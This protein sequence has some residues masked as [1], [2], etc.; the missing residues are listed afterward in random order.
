MLDI[1]AAAQK[2]AEPASSQILDELAQT[3]Y[4]AM[5]SS[6]QIDSTCWRR[7]YTDACLLRSLIDI[8]NFP[9]SDD[10]DIPKSVIERLDCV[11]I[12][13]GAPGEGRRDLIIDLISKIQS[14]CLP[15]KA[16]DFSAFHD[17]SHSDSSQVPSILTSSGLIPRLSKPPSL[18]QFSRQFSQTPFILPGYAADWPALNEHPWRSKGYLKS[19]AGRGRVVPVEVGS[20]YRTE[21]WSQQMMEWDR[22][23]E[24]LDTSPSEKNP[25]LYLA[26][27]N[28]LSQF[29]A[30]RADIIVPDYVYTC[31]AAPSDYP[32]YRPPGNE[33]QLVIN[34]WLGPKGTV[35]PAHTDPYFNF[36]VQ[37]VGR[38]TVW[39]APPGATPSM[40]PYPPPT[41][42][43]AVDRRYNPV[44]N[45]LEP[46]MSNTSRVDVFASP[47]QVDQ[48]VQQNYPLFW[49]DVVP[50]ATSV[51]LEPG[52]VL[53]F[54]PGWWHAMRSEE[55]S[56]SV[57]MWF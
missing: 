9:K 3:A 43:S 5:S 45:S 49:Q 56:F 4:K 35:S 25:I 48:T 8:K 28:L 2:P 52:D 21:D 50:E 33:H 54:P 41:R 42:S 36:Y 6:H 11:L 57:S 37:V 19:I 23:L 55:T 31:P 7:L 24:C 34:A 30:L 14:E 20:D 32:H 16:F 46:S 27:H 13:A 17:T 18:I 44:A 40:Y 39:L 53:F 29:P 22:F 12:I 26:Q 51:T 47:S 1:R 10:E 38:K 15:S